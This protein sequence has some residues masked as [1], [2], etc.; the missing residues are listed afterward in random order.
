MNLFSPTT[1][2]AACVLVLIQLLAA[3]PWLWVLDPKGFAARAKSA[4]GWFSMIGVIA[5]GGIAL[6]AIMLYRAEPGKLE[7]DGRIYAS[8]LHL[9]LA[10]DLILAIL[11]VML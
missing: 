7:I 1:F 11:G 10:L 5:G 8:I 4:S 2:A 6:T 3:L 9:Q